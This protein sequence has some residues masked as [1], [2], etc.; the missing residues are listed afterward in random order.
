MRIL[1]T[2]ATGLIGC[3]A[4][5]QLLSKGHAVRVFVRDPAKVDEVFEPF[6]LS[7]KDFEIAVGDVTDEKSVAAALRGCRGLLHSAG[8]F[9]PHL[10]DS[11]L[12]E[13]VN[14][15][16]TRVVLETSREAGIERV[17]FI[18]SMLALFPP[19]GSKMTADDAV[20]EPRS[21]YA[22]TKARAERLARHLQLEGMPLTTLY[23]GAC[24]G[25]HDP[26]LSTG[27]QL[28]ANA[29][30]DRRVLVTEGGLAYSDVRDL[31]ALV[32]AIFAG[33]TEVRRIMAPAFFIDHSAYHA[34]LVELTECDLRALRIPGWLMRAMGRLG[35]LSQRWGR[36]ALLTS[37]AVEVLTR[38]VPIDDAEARRILGRP[39]LCA[40]SSFRDLLDWMGRA[41]HLGPD[42]V[43]GH[44]QSK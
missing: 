27:P 30:R 5:S 29:I 18:S 9:S 39:G 25:P 20:T 12:L 14:V 28:V 22:L 17:V 4:A 16:G 41:G 8:L 24:H 38:S 10:S 15:E 33:A 26:T 37:E 36:D 21:M 13:R 7:E 43:P 32:A 6:G 2:G 44:G 34:L 42:R 31:A 40:E 1:V 3:H 19:A 35:D 23:P 11:A